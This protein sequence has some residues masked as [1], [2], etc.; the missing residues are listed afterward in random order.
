MD[1]QPCGR[2]G[3]IHTGPPVDPDKIAAEMAQDIADQID[4]EVYRELA[5]L[6]FVEAFRKRGL[7]ND[8]TRAISHLSA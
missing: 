2:C 1:N 6:A 4:A 3:K 5:S 8:I 7:C